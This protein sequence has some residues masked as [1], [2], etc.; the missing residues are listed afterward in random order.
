MQQLRSELQKQLDKLSRNTSPLAVVPK[1]P[2]LRNAPQGLCNLI[3]LR[4]YYALEQHPGCY[5]PTNVYRSNELFIVIL[6]IVNP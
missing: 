6:R 1:D 5:F 4:T 3:D 2:G